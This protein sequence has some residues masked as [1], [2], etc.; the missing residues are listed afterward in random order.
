MDTLETHKL[1]SM[2]TTSKN[3]TYLIMTN[4]PKTIGCNLSLTKTDYKDVYIT[5][6]RVERDTN[7]ISAFNLNPLHLY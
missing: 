7:T 2:Q 4:Q 1:R 3:Q 5:Y 6:D